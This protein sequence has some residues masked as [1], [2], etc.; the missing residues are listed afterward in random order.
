MHGCT[1]QQARWMG[2]GGGGHAAVA[3]AFRNGDVRPNTLA[4]SADGTRSSPLLY[5]HGY[6]TSHHDHIQL[7]FAVHACVLERS[8]HPS[9]VH[10]WIVRTEIILLRFVRAWNNWACIPFNR[11]MPGCMR[12]TIIIGSPL[13]RSRAAVFK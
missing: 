10:A 11:S 12:S 7:A 4:P 5:A 8:I 1:A 13:L 6:V 3:G 9:S 2:G